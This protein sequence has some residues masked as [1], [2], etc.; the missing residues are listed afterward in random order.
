MSV[1]PIRSVTFYEI[2]K[3]QFHMVTDIPQLRL[4]LF[5]TKQANNFSILAV[6][7]LMVWHNY[8][9]SD[10]YLLYAKITNLNKK[11]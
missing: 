7:S 3:K 10:K 8:L 1:Y 6:R 9:K 4:R 2:V 5:E 11:D